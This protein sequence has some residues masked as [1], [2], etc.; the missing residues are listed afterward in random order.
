VDIGI[1]CGTSCSPGG[2]N[3]NPGP[4]TF[5]VTDVTIA[6]FIKNDAGLYFAADLCVGGFSAAQRLHGKH[7]QRRRRYRPAGRSKHFQSPS[8]FRSLSLVYFAQAPCAS[9]RARALNK[10]E[11]IRTG[12]CSMGGHKLHTPEYRW[13]RTSSRRNFSETLERPWWST[14]PP[15]P[16]RSEQRHDRTDNRNA[17]G[18]RE[19][20]GHRDRDRCEPVRRGLHR[21]L[22]LRGP[23]RYRHRPSGRL[24]PAD[25]G[26]GGRGRRMNNLG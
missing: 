25:R 20:R 16:A 9:A 17:G 23:G 6:D 5:T 12:N 3:P 11:L 2:S 13:E 22:L 24:A 21:K 19:H 26:R 8:R 7:R 15:P 10:M 4:L 18:P 14:R 1:Y